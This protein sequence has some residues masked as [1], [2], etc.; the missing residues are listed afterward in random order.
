[1]VSGSAI[2]V[3]LFGFA[4]LV[5]AALILVAGLAVFGSMREDICDKT[6]YNNQEIN[7]TL[8][9]DASAINIT[10][11]N[12]TFSNSSSYWN[13]SG[14]TAATF[15]SATVN[16]TGLRTSSID[17]ITVDYNVS[18]TKNEVTTPIGAGGDDGNLVVFYNDT[19]GLGGAN[20]SY[21]VLDTASV[22]AGLDVKQGLSS[23][24]SSNLGLYIVGFTNS[25]GRFETANGSA[26]DGMA[27]GYTDPFSTGCDQSGAGYDTTNSSN[28]AF[29]YH[30]SD[31]TRVLMSWYD[32]SWNSGVVNQ[33]GDTGYQPE[34]FY[35]SV[36]SR[37]DV[38]YINDDTNSII[39]STG[40]PAAIMLET[41]VVSS[42]TLSKNYPFAVIYNESSED[43]YVYFMDAGDIYLSVGQAG[44][45]GGAD[46]VDTGT[47]Y[48]IDR[49]LSRTEDG[50]VHHYLFHHTDEYLRAIE[51]LPD[52][53]TF[54]TDWVLSTASQADVDYIDA[55]SGTNDSLNVFL[56]DYEN[57]VDGIFFNPV[58]IS[59]PSNFCFDINGDGSC[60][61]EQTGSFNST[62]TTASLASA[63]SSASCSTN[64]C[65]VSVTLSSDTTGIV[66]LSGVDIQYDSYYEVC[67]AEQAESVTNTITGLGSFGGWNTTLIALI[68]VVVILFLVSG[69][70]LGLK[71]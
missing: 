64:P 60:E 33:T 26:V 49:V 4:S 18:S 16:L 20:V 7:T 31:A 51:F 9:Y 11:G 53:T 15:S 62:N 14:L 25:T 17:S 22:N 2:K 32:G 67:S 63:L 34:V 43:Y 68:A 12:A 55:V 48:G 30:C 47:Y 52:S 41:E 5:I 46:L 3:M 39:H 56:D 70:T 36:H 71:R 21:G 57:P 54:V 10:F 42:P 38:F 40:S 29:V 6:D 37:W 65:S 8:P 28:L 24:Y 45:Y 66:T 1:M 61:F 35:D 23:L 50:V 69:A 27:L 58:N 13:I 44:A 19:A 59:Y